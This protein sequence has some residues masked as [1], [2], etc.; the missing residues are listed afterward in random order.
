MRFPPR[1]RQL[2]IL[3]AVMTFNASL[4]WSESPASEVQNAQAVVQ[5]PFTSVA[6]VIDSQPIEMGQLVYFD[7]AAADAVG[8]KVPPGRVGLAEFDRAIVRLLGREVRTGTKKQEKV[9][10][11][12][13]PNGDPFFFVEV[14][15][16][17][18][19]GRAGYVEVQPGVWVNMKGIGTT[20]EGSTTKASPPSDI[21]LSHADGSATLE[22]ALKEAIQGRVAD[23]ELKRGGSRVIAIISTGRTLKYPDG[24]VVQLATIIRTPTRRYDRE[25]RRYQAVKTLGEA[26]ARRLM[27]GDFVNESNMGAYGEMVDY[28]CMTH[29]CGYARLKSSQGT[30]FLKEQE[31]LFE[32]SGVEPMRR[33]IGRNLLNQMGIPEEYISKTLD[34]NTEFR[35]RLGRIGETFQSVVTEFGEPEALLDMEP[36]SKEKLNGLVPW[37]EYFR[38]AVGDWVENG[39]DLS[40]Q[41]VSALVERETTKLHSM[42]SFS[43]HEAFKTAIRKFLLEATNATFEVV[44]DNVRDRVAFARA[45]RE[46]ARFKNRDVPNLVRPEIIRQAGD[47]AEVFR[48][49]NNASAV[50]EFIENT[51]LGNRY[52]T[53]PATDSG[54]II[55]ADTSKTEIYIRAFTDQ[56]GN[57]K[58]FAYPELRG[59]SHG[60]SFGFRVTTDGWSSSSDLRSEFVH[61][62]FGDYFRVSLPHRSTPFTW[63]QVEVV[64]FVK[65]G[66]ETMHWLA[67]S[68]NI[69]GPPLVF[70][71]RFDLPTN[72]VREKS[73]LFQRF[74]VR[75]SLTPDDL[76][77]PDSK[78]D[79]LS[80]RALLDD[81]SDPLPMIRGDAQTELSF[82]WD[83]LKRSAATSEDIRSKLLRSFENPNVPIYD[84]VGM[85]KPWMKDPISSVDMSILDMVQRRVELAWSKGEVPTRFYAEIYG[86]LTPAQ[87]KPYFK[88]LVEQ[89]RNNPQP[90]ALYRVLS[91]RYVLENSE[92]DRV[93][94]ILIQKNPSS[95]ALT[96]EILGNTLLDNTR[97]ERL[98]RKLIARPNFHPAVGYLMSRIKD[99]KSLEE[100]LAIVLAPKNKGAHQSLVT[101]WIGLL[102]YDELSANLLKR[103]LLLGTA[104]LQIAS[105]LGKQGVS[106]VPL[107]L[108]IAKRLSESENLEVAQQVLM[109]LTGEEWVGKSSERVKI[110]ESHFLKPDKRAVLG[111]L[112]AASSRFVEMTPE[113]GK[114]L[115]AIYRD[116]TFRDDLLKLIGKPEWAKKPESR[117]MIKKISSKKWWSEASPTERSAAR[118]VFTDGLVE[119]PEGASLFLKA[120]QNV[121]PS[122]QALRA[123]E[124]SS[125]WLDHHRQFPQLLEGLKKRGLLNKHFYLNAAAPGPWRNHP[126]QAEIVEEGFRTGAYDKFSRLSSAEKNPVLIHLCGKTPLDFECLKKAFIDEGKT[127]K[128]ALESPDPALQ[129]AASDLIEAY[130]EYQKVT[131]LD[132]PFIQGFRKYKRACL[133]RQLAAPQAGMIP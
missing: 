75:S 83:E 104:D 92:V 52:G 42:S 131:L 39:K 47:V 108:E 69:Q 95:S 127:A 107:S 126:L 94:A 59:A 123:I 88:L 34:G 58:M 35:D 32:G 20:G 130:M 30:S 45:V 13:N 55:R 74:G 89:A 8:M 2:G 81:L 133:M 3:L 11:N 4:A 76:I 10:S 112:K 97:M 27:K 102:P 93:I 49:N 121:P 72:F 6:A 70:N 118:K 18:G 1:A 24:R 15:S 101:D 79:P 28:G 116:D 17:G 54:M 57:Q 85:A 14:D 48:R 63:K 80:L 16:W 46:V 100:I 129:K 51:V 115:L 61:T 98:L 78:L 119:N 38:E 23:A 67:P 36:L 40:V 44:R 90:E 86:N 103:I 26:N 105:V 53:T 65:D 41:E 25:A 60:E 68:L 114:W 12:K 29:T 37:H 96:Q 113:T 84:F 33:E 21:F 64:P 73:R 120:L 132:A 56:Q 82:R 122:E 5:P 50:Q 43:K 109:S 124:F 31:L 111:S 99:A 62:P 106:R 110:F 117:V 128:G 22:E 7:Q 87:K 71:E 19:A 9:S 77:A 125:D 66:G 91:D